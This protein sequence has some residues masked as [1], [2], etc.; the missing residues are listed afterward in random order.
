MGPKNKQQSNAP[1]PTERKHGKLQNQ[2]SQSH[3]A[4]DLLPLKLKQEILDVFSS[5]FPLVGRNDLPRVIQEVKGHLY[6]RDF[7]RAFGTPDYLDAYAL[8][9][10]ALRALAYADI[11]TTLDIRYRWAEIQPVSNAL[12][13]HAPDNHTASHACENPGPHASKVV[14]IG[15]GAGAEVVALAAAIRVHSWPDMTVAV[16]DI[17]DWSQN[18]LKIRHSLTTPPT[19]SAYASEAVKAA[20]RSLITPN[21][22]HVEFTKQDI[23]G[24]KEDELRS[25]LAGSS[26]VTIMFTLNELFTISIPRT[27]AF[28]LALSDAIESDSWLLVVDSPGSYSEVKLGK[29]GQLK[30]YPMQWL[31]DHTLLHV[32]GDDT[33]GNG[34]WRKVLG[35]ESRWFR[36][37]S[38]LMY[39]IELEN[40]RFQMHLFHRQD[41]K[42]R[43]G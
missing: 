16:V 10:S 34:Q 5:A 43:L 25:L 30:K 36:V 40:M 11:L 7:T 39:P 37:G 41:R 42:E 33:K 17:A 13:T 19:L 12:L 22:L 28:L 1:R 35:E 2:P 4:G 31:L 24:F 3:L 15:G 8:R 27:T 20:N 32:A 38:D 14:C 9:W 29:D 26:L 21:Q 23:L 6:N 18:L